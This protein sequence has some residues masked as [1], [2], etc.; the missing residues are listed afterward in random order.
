[1]KNKAEV[2]DEFHNMA[3]NVYGVEYARLL[4]EEYDKIMGDSA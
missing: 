1:M 4:M 2:R 3:V